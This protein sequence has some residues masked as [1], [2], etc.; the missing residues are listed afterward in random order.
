MLE[1]ILAGAWVLAAWFFEGFYSTD[2][3]LPAAPWWFGL[4]LLFLT[5]HL[6]KGRV[7]QIA[8]GL[9]LFVVPSAY[10]L[11]L[12]NGVESVHSTLT[13]AMTWTMTASVVLLF[14]L[15]TLDR[16]PKRYL[17]AILD[18]VAGVILAS[19]VISALINAEHWYGTVTGEG[20]Y[21]GFL[22]YPNAAAT[23]YLSLILYYSIRAGR[24]AP[25]FLASAAALLSMTDSFAALGIL[26][27]V[28]AVLM[29]QHKST[30]LQQAAQHS[31]PL[32]LT[33]L[34]AGL[35]PPFAA[36]VTT[37]MLGVLHI[38]FPLADHFLLYQRHARTLG[39]SLLLLLSAGGVAA[40]VSGAGATMVDRA[41]YWRD[42]LTE[43]AGTLPLGRG[44]DAWQTMMYRAQSS[45]YISHELHSSLVTWAIELGLPLAAL[46]TAGIA[47]II[48]RIHT[49]WALPALGILLHSLVDFTLA[50]PLIVVLTA[51]FMMLAAYDLKAESR[52]TPGPVIGGVAAALMMLT[53]GFG[54]YQLQQAEQHMPAQPEAALEAYPWH[55][56][57]LLTQQNYERLLE[58]I[59]YHAAARF[60]LGVEK[61]EAGD[62]E[63]GEAHIR[64]AITQD[65]F[66]RAKY[67]VWGELINRDEAHARYEKQLDAWKAEPVQ[68]NDQRGFVED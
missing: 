20:A 21:A 7:R 14:W 34:L 19:S 12:L 61:I 42:A 59:P 27:V 41:I 29:I 2:V 25:L 37:L 30:A 10:M 63:T 32:T 49:F 57:A 51:V 47:L 3:W 45:P 62:E 53:A 35:L 55:T 9:V 67:E 50:F 1:W 15:G 8:P 68:L 23:V 16:P 4:V 33:A 44:G 11:T 43:T 39:M 54:T 56:G 24:L 52:G 65:P 64:Q 18:T 26:L 38:I 46:F 17:L 13:S 48:R 28:L 40:F 66:D 22:G 60:Q 36:F 31:L 6:M 5:Y 58:V